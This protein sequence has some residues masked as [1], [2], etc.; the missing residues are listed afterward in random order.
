MQKCDG[1]LPLCGPCARLQRDDC[2][3]VQGKSRGST[4]NLEK[5]V[6]GLRA[7][8]KELQDAGGDTAGPSRSHTPGTAIQQ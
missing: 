5:K 7:R 6:A 2:E 1:A 8:L 4:H 3:Y